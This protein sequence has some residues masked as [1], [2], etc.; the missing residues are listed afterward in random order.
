MMHAMRLSTSDYHRT[1]R[2]KSRKLCQHQFQTSMISIPT[3]GIECTD[4]DRVEEEGENGDDTIF[5]I[6][7]ETT[8]SP[9]VLMA[10]ARYGCYQE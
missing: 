5:L 4:E 7:S 6:L 3:I 8:L 2:W 9:L 10:L 1:I